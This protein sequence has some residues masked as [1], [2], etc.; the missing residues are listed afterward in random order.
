MGVEDRFPGRSG[1]DIPHNKHGIFAGISG[2]YDIEFSIIG[3][4]GDLVA[5]GK[6]RGT[7]PCSCLCWLFS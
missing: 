1:S 2:D 3:G 4:G 6:G 5:L 7:C